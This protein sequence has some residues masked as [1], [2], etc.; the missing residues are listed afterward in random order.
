MKLVL[1]YL[2]ALALASPNLFAA[3]IN[4]DRISEFYGNKSYQANNPDLVKVVSQS[5]RWSFINSLAFVW[6]LADLR[7][8][9]PLLITFWESGL[10]PSWRS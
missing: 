1:V 5:C 2:C 7:P 4:V 6:A 8:A 10:G 9:L 3:A